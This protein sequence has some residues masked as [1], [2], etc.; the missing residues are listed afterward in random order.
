M[1]LALSL[2]LTDRKTR[3]DFGSFTPAANCDL[4]KASAKVVPTPMTSPVDFISGPRMVSTPGNLTKGKTASLTEKYGGMTSLVT[5]CAFR[6]LPDMQRAAIL[7]SCRPVALETYGTVR[8]A[9]GF[10]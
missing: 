10:T 5:P 7:A 8:K 1:A 2:S 6:L 9:R 3:P 4:T